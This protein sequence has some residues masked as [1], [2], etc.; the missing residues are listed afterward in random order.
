MFQDEF[1]LE[2]GYFKPPNKLQGVLRALG[3][4]PPCW[5]VLENDCT[6]TQSQHTQHFLLPLL[7]CCELE[8]CP[9]SPT[10]H[11]Y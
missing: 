11:V 3:D 8:P 6:V 4:V 2:K 7:V 10:D 1:V 9:G 5:M